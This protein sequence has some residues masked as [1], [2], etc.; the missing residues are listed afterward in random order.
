MKQLFTMVNRIS[1]QGSGLH[2]QTAVIVAVISVGSSMY[3]AFRFRETMKQIQRVFQILLN[4]FCLVVSSALVKESA[5]TSV[6]QSLT[7]S[8]R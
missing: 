4:H 5:I 2:S 6:A 1:D 7:S 3:N 8:Y